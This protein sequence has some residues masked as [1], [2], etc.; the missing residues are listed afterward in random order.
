MIIGLDHT[1]LAVRDL[2]AA[3]DTFSAL[4]F[5]LTPRELLTRPGPDGK[6]VSTGAANHV[7]MLE[8]GYQELITITDPSAGHMLLPRLDRYWGLHIVI[9]ESDD[10][11]SDRAAMAKRGIPVSECTTWGRE[12]PGQGEAR[13]RF[14]VVA[15]SEAPECVLGIVQ[16][17]TP[18][19]IRPPELLAH[20][21]RAKAIVGCTLCVRDAAEAS[22]RYA[23]ILG[24]PTSGTFRFPGGTYL[25]LAEHATLAAR[26]PGAEL[27]AAPSLAAVEFAVRD[28]AALESGGVPLVRD[29][30][31]RRLSPSLGF[32]AVIAFSPA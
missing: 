29:G 32:G 11:E 8:R 20:R 12:V 25:A 10:A 4:G 31:S 15:D 14:F 6:Q 17:L 26:H 13:F 19:K 27:P 3:R 9:L 16:H 2:D 5:T 7:F 30:A 22:T 24:L 1:G 21:N 28:M 18:E 23:R